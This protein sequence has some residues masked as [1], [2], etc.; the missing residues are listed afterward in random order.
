MISY[1]RFEFDMQYGMKKNRLFI[2]TLTRFHVWK[3][4]KRGYLCKNVACAFSVCSDIL[5][6]ESVTHAETIICINQ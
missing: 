4:C 5:M 6:Y 3:F 2:S 1:A